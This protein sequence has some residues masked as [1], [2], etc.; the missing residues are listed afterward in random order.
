[1]K[2]EIK[3]QEK[4]ITRFNDLKKGE[5]FTFTS[6]YADNCGVIGIKTGH[7][8]EPESSYYVRLD[9]GNHCYHCDNEIVEIFDATLIL[10]PK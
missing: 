1:M 7:I 4:K 10:N 9:N 5:C 3:K 2:I 8:K 6:G